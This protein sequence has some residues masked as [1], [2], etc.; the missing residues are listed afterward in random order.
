MK[1]LHIADTHLGYSAYRKTTEEG[2]NQRELDV[3]RAFEEFVDYAIKTQPDFILHC[4]DLFDNVRPNNRAIGF[5]IDQMIRLSEEKIPLI[6]IAGNHEHP[7]IKETGSIFQIFDHIENTYPVYKGKYEQIKLKIKKE[8]ILIHAI[9]QNNSKDDFKKQLQELIINKEKDYNIFMA[10]G[11]VT[12]I[13]EFKMNEFNELFIPAEYLSKKY[14]YIALGHYHR[15]TQ[16]A[17]NAYYSGSIENLTFTDAGDKKGFL[18]IKLEKDKLQNNFIEIKHREMIDAKPIKCSDLKLDQIMNKI[19]TTIKEIKP[20]EKTF[21][22][23]LDDIPSSIYRSLDFNEIRKTSSEAIHYEIKA[24]VTKKDEIKQ[25]TNSKIDRLVNEYKQ[26]LETK[27]IE[28][29]QTIQELGIGYIE[30]IEAR[31]EGK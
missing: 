25:N 23:T 8:E 28:N 26:Y 16:L 13:K 10:H 4:G 31:E 14:D 18:E 22:I 30:K 29:K 9:P 19:K 7:K 15:Y 12:G 5:A 24:N 6:I 1:F 3:Y 21:R 17:A 27:D 2:I 20:K 11:S